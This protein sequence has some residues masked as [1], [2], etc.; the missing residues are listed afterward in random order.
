[1]NNPKIK[2]VIVPLLTPFDAQGQVD[3][4]AVKRLVDF[5]IARGVAGLFPG[6][7][8]GEGPLLTA[9]ERRR[10][11]ETAVRAADGRAPVIVHTGAITTR[12][13]V[14]L[15]CH[16]RDIGAQ[17]AALIPPYYYRYP[18]EAIFRHYAQ[19]AEQAPDFPIYLYNNPHVTGAALSMA[20]VAA[21][22]ERFPNIAGLKDSSDSLDILAA[23]LSW[24]GGA[25]NAASGND[26]LLLGALAMGVDACVSG[27]ANVV[28][29]LVVAL[30]GAAARGDL[31]TARALQAK[32]N[33]VRAILRDGA[34]LSLFKGILTQRGLPL[35]AVR[36]PL[37]PASEAEITERW[38]ALTALGLELT[39][40]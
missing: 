13:A 19:V 20:L 35:G 12:E 17:A 1:M 28:P 7:T 29:E 33:R 39:P 38:R 6:G 14:E 30:Y 26:G 8:T 24:R 11:A 34:D 27:N 37:L 3:A 5:L 25:F 10:L 18:D 22:V 23:S 32:L 31:E 2:G 40:V 21:L 9:Q 15:T 16:A 36:S 4:P